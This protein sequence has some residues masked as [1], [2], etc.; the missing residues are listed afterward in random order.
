VPLGLVFSKSECCLLWKRQCSE[1]PLVFTIKNVAWTSEALELWSKTLGLGALFGKFGSSTGNETLSSCSSDR[2]SSFPPWSQ[3]TGSHSSPSDF[4]WLGCLNHS[5]LRSNVTFSK[6]A[7]PG[8]PPPSPLLSAI[9]LFVIVVKV[10]VHI[11]WL[12]SL[13]SVSCCCS[14]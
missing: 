6:K 1:I 8:A 14:Q 7:V 9:Y 4:R 2:P 3:S 10:K 11:S 12:D 5:G 13:L